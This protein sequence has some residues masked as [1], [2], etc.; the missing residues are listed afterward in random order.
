MIRLTMLGWLVLGLGCGG[1]NTVPD[2]AVDLL[3]ADARGDGS[4]FCNA[5]DPRTAP[6]E[7]GVQPDD[8]EKAYVEMIGRA[9]KSI[10]VLI[11]IMGRGGIL[12]GLKQQATAGKDVRVILDQGQVTTNQKYYDE[13]KAAG[14]KVLWSDP[15]FSYMHAKVMIGDEAEAVVSTGNYSLVYSIQSER[16]FTGRTTD[17]QDVADLVALFEADWARR[18]GALPCTRLLVSP[19]NARARILALLASAQTSLVIES[20]Q[21]ADTDVR[22]AVA[23]RQKAGVDVRVLLADPGWIDANTD[24]ATFLKAQGIAVRKLAQPAVHTK[25]FVVDGKTAYLGSINFSYT[26][27]SK[28][29]EVGL[30]FSDAVGVQRITST[31]EKDWAT[32]TA[33]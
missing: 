2:L 33:L 6:V 20:M 1:S 16:N 17:A 28:N 23:A 10:R 11:Y 9:Q 22:N 29:R 12:D 15:Q 8:G 21:L 32:A 18:P 3:T 31:F 25:D 13:L 27:L 7:V 4:R 14:A 26:S 5:T 24:A 19:I 30:I